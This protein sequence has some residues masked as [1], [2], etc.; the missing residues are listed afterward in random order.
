MQCLAAFRKERGYTT[1]DMAADIGVSQSLYEKIEFG[2]RLP[3]R[4]FLK[5]FKE[6]YPDFDMNIFFDEIIH[7]SCI[8]GE[9]VNHPRIKD[10]ES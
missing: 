5:K 1:K 2:A 7:N 9:N 8:E 4:S 6:K 10:S 3:S